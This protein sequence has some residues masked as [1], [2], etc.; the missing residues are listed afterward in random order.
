MKN[1]RK[2]ISERRN[3]ICRGPRLGKNLATSERRHMW[4]RQPEG[5]EKQVGL[6]IYSEGN[7]MP[8]RHFQERRNLS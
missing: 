7:G 5:L 8:V 1:G 2:E 4:L 6:W 3:S